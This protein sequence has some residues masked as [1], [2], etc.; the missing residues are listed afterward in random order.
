[1]GTLR[2]KTGVEVHC[3]VQLCPGPLHLTPPGGHH[4]PCHIGEAGRSGS[5]RNT[6]SPCPVI[7]L[8]LGNPWS[9][10]GIQGSHCLPPCSK[11]E[12][13]CSGLCICSVPAWP[14]RRAA[15]CPASPQWP[16]SR[17]ATNG[18]VLADSVM[19]SRPGFI[20]GKEHAD[21]ALCTHPWNR[22]LHCPLC[23]S[24]CAGSTSLRSS[25]SKSDKKLSN[26]STLRK[27]I[28][29]KDIQRRRTLSRGATRGGHPERLTTG[30]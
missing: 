14:P 18:Q 25:S 21:Q 8:I 15:H 11:G 3:P 26:P 29:F 4:T 22:S 10:L 2:Q 23:L 28:K 17:S 9:D 24:D 16:W 19:N 27:T 12:A 13:T 7:N 1:M 20:T 6:P 30:G 5:Y